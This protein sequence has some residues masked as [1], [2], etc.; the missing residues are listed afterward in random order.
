[1]DEYDVGSVLDRDPPSEPVAPLT[2][3]P[4]TVDRGS[5][6]ARVTRLKA[7][8]RAKGLSV[9]PSEH[10]YDPEPRT[11]GD[12]WNRRMSA[13]KGPQI[14]GVASKLGP[15]LHA[16]WP[17]LDGC[18][19]LLFTS[20]TGSSYLARELSKRFRIGQMEESLNPHLVEGI[21][22]ADI[23]RSYANGWFSFKL[24]VPGII[25]AELS[26]AVEQYIESTYFIMLLRKDIVAQAVSLVKANQT[27]QWHS[28]SAPKREP[29]YDAAQLA[30]SIRIIANAVASLR[31]YIDRAERPW[32]KLFY[33][34]FEHG[35]FST[36]EAICDEFQIPRLAEGEGPKLV[37]LSRT[38][39][40]VNDVWR[41][42]F[43]EDIDERTSQVIEA[44]RASL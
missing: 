8:L 5:L 31:A 32:R 11:F 39:D 35:D 20:R 36:A 7:R 38:S 21:A 19:G 17:V 27:G 6:D 29:V 16:P 26:G 1:L 12:A 18:L 10:P 34:D 14:E 44:Y 2:R 9:E 43:C 15:V 41:A 13:F 23:I 24:G 33:E 42:R 40:E 30:T 4:S 22:P 25:S 3:A 37:A 28:I